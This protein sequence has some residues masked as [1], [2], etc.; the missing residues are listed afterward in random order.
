MLKKLILKQFNKELL[1]WIINMSLSMV[2]QG[3]CVK[4]ISVTGRNNLKKFS[5]LGIIPGT[6]IKVITN[7]PL[8]PFI[9]SV[10]GSRIMIGKDAANNIIVK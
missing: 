10:M 1:T 9:I 6:D 4:V 5:S 8:G 7:S 3:K 2:E